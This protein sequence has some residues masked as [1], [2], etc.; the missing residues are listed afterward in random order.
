V[1]E[2]AWV[3]VVAALNDYTRTHSHGGAQA[4]VLTFR[5]RPIVAKTA[6]NVGPYAGRLIEV[7]I[8]A[9]E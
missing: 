5:D 9:L 1:L 2:S 4:S 3:D 7:E 8:L 6:G